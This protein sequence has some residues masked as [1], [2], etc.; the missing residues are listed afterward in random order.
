PSARSWSAP[1]PSPRASTPPCGPAHPLP[2]P[3]WTPRPSPHHRQRHPQPAQRGGH[4]PPAATSR[5][6]SSPRGGVATPDRS[7]RQG[8]TRPGCY[9]SLQRSLQR[10]LTVALL[11]SCKHPEGWSGGARPGESALLPRP[12]HAG[13]DSAAPRSP[14][15]G[16]ILSRELVNAG[17]RIAPPPDQCPSPPAATVASR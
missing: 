11:V 14:T 3:E 10:L 1:P 2:A 12:G 5:G 13:T 9:Q 15:E 16:I 7:M 17:K 6:K 8:R 4:T